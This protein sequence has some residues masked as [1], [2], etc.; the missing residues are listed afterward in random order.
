MASVDLCELWARLA[1]KPGDPVVAEEARKHLVQFLSH[2]DDCD[3]CRSVSERMAEPGLVYA[4]LAETE[5]EPLPEAERAQ[6]EAGHRAFAEGTSAIENAVVN[7]LLLRLPETLQPPPAVAPLPLFRATDAVNVL[8]RSMSAEYPDGLLE[9][10]PAGL[11]AGE[12]LVATRDE[13]ASDIAEHASLNPDTADD[14]LTWQLNVLKAFPRLNLYRG[15]L[16]IPSEYGV[17]MARV[18]SKSAEELAQLWSDQAEPPVVEIPEDF[19]DLL[20]EPLLEAV[21][22]VLAVEELALEPVGATLKQTGEPE[23]G[24]LGELLVAQSETRKEEHEAFQYVVEHGFDPREQARMKSRLEDMLQ[25]LEEQRERLAAPLEVTVVKSPQAWAAAMYA[26]RQVTTRRTLYK[27]IVGCRPV[28][29]VNL[30]P[31][32][33]FCAQGIAWADLELKHLGQ[34][35]APPQ[36]FGAKIA[37]IF[38]GKI[39]KI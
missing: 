8:A 37:K 14:L 11:F 27:E 38:G 2:V 1:E 25:K 31:L 9:L 21:G 19:E 12:T 13:V 7:S 29:G 28:N 33:R 5:R 36:T 16:T 18:P 35:K 39:A 30:D 32:Q 22:A 6:L 17:V 10:T 23:L 20:P 24:E 26:R 3:K 34:F 15:L 4:A